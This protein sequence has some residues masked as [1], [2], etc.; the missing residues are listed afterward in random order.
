MKRKFTPE[1]H[2]KLVEGG[3]KGGKAEKHFT[4]DS[5]L[6]QIE[7]AKRGGKKSAEKRWQKK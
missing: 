7:G 6:R 5:K 3:R 1:S 2:K 4:P